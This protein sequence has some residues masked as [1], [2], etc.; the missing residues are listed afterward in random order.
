MCD[1]MCPEYAAKQGQIGREEF[2]PTEFYDKATS[3]ALQKLAQAAER[4]RCITEQEE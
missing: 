3:E 2:P 1:S 4:A